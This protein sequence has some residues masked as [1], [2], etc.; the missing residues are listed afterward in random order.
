MS[1]PALR[2]ESPAGH[3]SR[4]AAERGDG[5]P[6]GGGEGAVSPSLAGWHLA[7][8]WALEVTAFLDLGPGWDPRAGP[9]G[10]MSAPPRNFLCWATALLPLAHRAGTVGGGC[11]LLLAQ[12]LLRF[13]RAAGGS[14]GRGAEVVQG[15]PELGRRVGRGE[16]CSQIPAQPLS[17][18]DVGQ[19]VHGTITALCQ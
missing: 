6:A 16:D 12:G 13:R 15:S 19:V 14:G 17:L 7:V 4:L 9:L 1:Q 2:A 18:C 3:A 5:L 11:S 10:P 8:S